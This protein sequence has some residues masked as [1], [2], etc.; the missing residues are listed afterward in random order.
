MHILLN[1]V[2]AQSEGGWDLRVSLP[3]PNFEKLHMNFSI[4][5]TLEMKRL[6]D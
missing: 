6:S 4:Y 3:T 5:F 1:T 2:R